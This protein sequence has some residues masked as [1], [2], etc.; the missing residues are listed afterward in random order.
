MIN[1]KFLQEQKVNYPIIISKVQINNNYNNH[2]YN[3]YNLLIYNS[4]KILFLII[5]IFHKML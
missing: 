4:K 1:Q 2:K 5:I 3:F